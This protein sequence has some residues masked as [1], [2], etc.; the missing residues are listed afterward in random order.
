MRRGQAE[1]ESPKRHSGS[2][3]R[4]GVQRET[5]NTTLINS[6][7]GQRLRGTRQTPTRQPIDRVV[8]ANEAGPAWQMRRRDGEE[9]VDERNGGSVDGRTRYD[10][11]PR[12]RAAAPIAHAAVVGI[13]GG[14]GVG[15]I[16][17][18]TARAAAA[19]VGGGGGGD[20]GGGG[21]GGGNGG[22]RT[23]TFRVRSPTV[24]ERAGGTPPH[25]GESAVARART[26]EHA[27]AR[28]AGE[29]RTLQDE[30]R[31]LRATND[32]LAASQRAA[33]ERAR[34]ERDRAS[35]AETAAAAARDETEAAE[36]MLAD[37]VAQV[38]GLIDL[39]YQLQK[40]A[41]LST[42]ISPRGRN[43]T[44]AADAAGR[45]SGAAAA[46]LDA[47][48]HRISELESACRQLEARSVAR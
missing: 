26:L 17:G 32:G 21:G 33:S 19:G 1:K 11:G 16:T 20:G 22:L 3:E 39:V 43:D 6:R 45:G 27:L 24:V 36:R 42:T 4:E 12:P 25:E 30:I 10:D 40:S 15:N 7:H 28:T 37:K 34:H 8:R 13:S 14:D 5:T 9:R 44:S 2:D 31:V 41:H 48:N 38:E 29:C 23:E 47:A 46:A 18:L 35:A